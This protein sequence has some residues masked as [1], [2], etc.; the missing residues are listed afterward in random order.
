VVFG[1]NKPGV[2]GSQ[3]NIVGLSNL[4]N[5]TCT[6]TA[7]TVLFSYYVGTGTVQTSPILGP[8]ANQVAYVE[9]IPSGSKFHVLTGAGTGSSNG[10]IVAPVARAQET[11]RLMPA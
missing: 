1:V 10:T 2:S 8:N 9:S 5:G 3:A 7:P 11:P 4:Y 6:P